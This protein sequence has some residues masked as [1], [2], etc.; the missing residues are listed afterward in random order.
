M[1]AG[2]LMF[3]LLSVWI[4]LGAFVT[5]LVVIIF[6]GEGADM[7]VTLLPYTIA[8]S[9]TFAAGV[10]WANRRKSISEPGVSGQRIQAIASIVLN[11]ATFAVLLFSLQP[12]QYALL[13]LVIEGVFL[14][15][16]WK[17]YQR[18]VLQE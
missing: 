6:P 13:G 18:M 3:A 1:E 14:W 4:A 5:A 15:L 11:S 7:V 2:K 17:G 9:A 10:L 12:P 16:C 8:A